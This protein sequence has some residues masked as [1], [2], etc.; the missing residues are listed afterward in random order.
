MD[1]RVSI[2]RYIVEKHARQK[3]PGIEYESFRIIEQSTRHHLV[4]ECRFYNPATDYHGALTFFL[5]DLLPKQ[6][7]ERDSEEWKPAMVS[8]FEAIA[9]RVDVLLSDLSRV[10]HPAGAID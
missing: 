10:P 9:A 1:E 2:V 7:P 4:L 8:A 6:M 5:D 3:W